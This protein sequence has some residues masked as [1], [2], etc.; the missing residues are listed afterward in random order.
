[1]EEQFKQLITATWDGNLISKNER[2][3]LVNNGFAARES[4][5]NFLTA[6]GIKEMVNLGYLRP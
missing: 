3:W 5:Y 4:G 2:D 1:M 6:K